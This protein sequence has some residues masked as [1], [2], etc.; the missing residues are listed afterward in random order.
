MAEF[1]GRRCDRDGCNM[2]VENVHTTP[3]GWIK[4]TPIINGDTREAENT[5][6]YCSE[7]CHAVV[8]VERYESATD[9]RFQ[10]PATKAP[11]LGLNDA[12]IEG[13]KR[14]AHVRLHTNKGIVSETCNYC[15]METAPK[16][17]VG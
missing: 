4:M 15:Q 14:A 2:V 13:G 6:E 11:G 7:Y 10:R 8:A 16:E 12:R 3:A 17:K 5:K 9:K 1:K